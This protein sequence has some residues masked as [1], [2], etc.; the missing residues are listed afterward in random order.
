M[1]NK[2]LIKN[3]KKKKEEQGWGQAAKSIGG[4]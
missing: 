4:F 2:Y 3:L 1:T